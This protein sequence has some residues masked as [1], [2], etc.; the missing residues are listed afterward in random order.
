METRYINIPELALVVVVETPTTAFAAKHFLPQEVFEFGSE[1]LEGIVEERLRLGKLTVIAVPFEQLSQIKNLLTLARKYNVRREAIVLDF[2]QHHDPIALLH[3]HGVHSVHVINQLDKLQEI[4]INKN[5]LPI[6]KKEH[7]GPFDIIGDIHGCFDELKALTLKL[8]YQIEEVDGNFKVT[9]PHQRKLVFVGD[10]VDR[11]PKI[12]EVLHFVIDAKAQGMAYCVI[13]NHEERL[14]RKLNNKEVALTHGLQESVDQL[15]LSSDR[16]RE[17][18]KAFLTE[19]PSHYVFDHGKL[20]IAHAGLK[21]K[22]LDRTSKRIR[23]FCMYGDTTGEV[24]ELGLPVRLNWAKKYTGS[25]KI[26]YGHT[27]IKTPQWLNN[28]INIDT[29]CV[30]GGKLTALRYSE[31]EVVQVNALQVYYSRHL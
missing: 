1:I 13:G 5:K 2:P 24:D 19:L 10:L 6:D 18:V 21:Q 15:A 23:S 29:G 9:H 14:L 17:Q 7:E 20:A 3:K 28:T 26:V 30:F 11:G 31:M 16:F 22:Y 4:V 12:A 8:G 25:T 27:P